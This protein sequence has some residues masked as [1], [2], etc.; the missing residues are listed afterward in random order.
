MQKIL[1]D[2]CSTELHL[3]CATKEQGWLKFKK[4]IESKIKDLL[5]LHTRNKLVT[6]LAHDTN[7]R[8]RSPVEL[9][10]SS[11]QA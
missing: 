4:L 8:P 6:L 2:G 3:I 5:R 11:H 10:L 1:E 7:K 9:S